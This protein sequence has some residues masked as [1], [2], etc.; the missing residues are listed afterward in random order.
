MRFRVLG[1]G[2]PVVL[3]HG[4]PSPADDLMPLAER[5]AARHRVLVPELPGYGGSA[6][7]DDASFVRVTAALV[8][9]LAD[10][11]AGEPHAIVGFSGGAY[12]A[13]HLALRGGV[14]P[15]VVVGLG[16]L[17]TLDDASREAF[18]GFAAA[19]TADPAAVTSAAFRGLMAERMLSPA[20]RAAHP[21]DADR[22]ADWLTLT[23][24]TYLAAELLA[25][26]EL[27]DL[28]ADLPSLAARVYLRTGGLD[29]ATPPALA[30][31]IA[32][33]VPGA[34]FDAVAGCGHALLIED[35]AATI[36][37]ITAALA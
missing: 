30:A 36:D 23:S 25:T 7:L 8:R 20:W 11:D 18:R 34:R 35:A 6:P 3:I 27:E 15:R 14:R 12:R 21:A 9:A 13:L 22:V 2:A 10:H 29:V 31:D 16:A 5:L 24:P 19:I 37:A 1:E 32:A 33:R 4:T 17:A 26:A 28:R